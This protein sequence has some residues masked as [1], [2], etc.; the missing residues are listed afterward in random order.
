MLFPRRV[1]YHIHGSDINYMFL[2][3]C[4]MSGWD[5]RSRWRSSPTPSPIT[6]IAGATLANIYGK[7]A[8]AR[9]RGVAGQ[10]Q[11]DSR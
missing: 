9:M 1:T 8:G 6:T 5:E 2:L 3:L 4:E 10:F 7:N 11:Y